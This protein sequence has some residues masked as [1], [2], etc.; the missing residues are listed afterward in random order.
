MSSSLEH[1][2]ACLPVTT[3]QLFD[4]GG[5]R[6]VLLGQGTF[7]RLVEENSGRVLAYLRVFKINHVHGYTVLQRDGGSTGHVQ[8]VAWGGQS[9]RLIELSYSISSCGEPVV[10]LVA[11]SAEY[12]A[13]DWVLAGCPSTDGSAAYLVTAHNAVLGMSVV[14][15]ANRRAIHLRQL[16][17]GVKSILY[18]A[19]I[20]PV[21]PT[22]LLVAAGTVFGE[23]IVWSCFLYDGNGSTANAISSIHHFFT[24]HEGSIFDVEISPKIANL[25]GD[26]SGR[27]LASCSDDRTVRIWDIS[28][29]E[30]ASPDQPSAYSTDGF[31]LRCTGFGQVKN[32]E[33]NAE[34][35][36]ASAFGHGARIW[37]IHFLA[38]Q[39]TKDKISLISRGEDAQCLVWDL[40]WGSS[41]ESKFK[42]TN[43]CSLHPHNGK[44]IWSLGMLTAGSKTTVYTG[45]NDGA[46]RTFNLVQEAGELVCP[47]R[48]T[49]IDDTPGS[50]NIKGGGMRAYEFVTPDHFLV[51][52]T[53]GEIQI[54]WAE[55]PNTADRRIACETLFV[56]ED[57]SSYSIISGLP[58][59]GVA[60]IG[61]KLGV[62]RL[63]DHET[64]S[65][66]TVTTAGQ[67]P[68]GLYLLDHHKCSDGSAN[69]KILATYT[70]LDTAEVFH[71]HLS[72]EEPHGFGISCASLIHNNEYL[73][74]GSRY[75]SFAVYKLQETGS[76]EPLLKVAR[77]HSKDGLT[78]IIPFTSLSPTDSTPSQYFLTSGRDAN[79][80]VNEL[81]VNGDA[82]SLRTVHSP[83][84]L[85]F[86]V[87]GAYIDNH[88]DLILYG[89]GG[90]GFVVWNESTQAEIAKIHCGGGHRRWAFHPSTR[91][92][93]SLLL[94]S[95]GG[96][97]ATHINAQAT[98]IK[99]LGT[100]QPVKG[101]PL[102]VTGSPNR[103]GPWGALETQR[104]LTA[105][106]SSPQHIACA[107]EDFFV[108]KIRT[109]PFFGLA[110]AIQGHCPKSHP[111]SEL[112]AEA[113]ANFLLCQTYS[114]STIKVFH[115]SCANE[116]GRFTLLASGTYTSNCLTQVRF[117]RTPS[118]LCLVTT[119]TDGHFT[120]WDI[121]AVLEQFY[122]LDRPLRLKQPLGSLSIAEETI[123]CEIR[124]QIHSNSIKTIDMV[125]LSDT[126]TLLLAGGDDNAITLTLLHTDTETGRPATITIPDAH[127]ASV[128][129][130]K[131]IEESIA[132]NSG[133]VQL[134]FASSGN[135]HRVKLW[136]VTID[137][138]DRPVLD[139][140]Q[141]DNVLDRYSPVADISSLDV[142][143][144][145]E[146]MKLLVC[147]VGMEW[148]TVEL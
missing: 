18:S 128:N 14:E 108:W 36:V 1:V 24:G 6:F 17:A 31:E 71:V 85:G 141:V 4:L 5:V 129:A 144:N 61:N 3:L 47:N 68:V 101:S 40:I 10:S 131:A 105:H 7:A 52:T 60:V 11:A 16:V 139:G 96:F 53:S 21:S 44:H 126:V 9:L 13:P 123:A 54:A 39:I 72:A 100:Y 30:I 88:N 57:L 49:R 15:E 134:S 38:E 99:A 74:L 109:I 20:V 75:G 12:L 41:S 35:C 146:G 33:L 25:R 62:V 43:T 65:L 135:D 27:L 115:L 73:G 2:D 112:R 92:G 50:E 42:L 63:Y 137:M 8:L 67:R 136:R 142:V 51:V 110:A 79:Y 89:F 29:C 119:S 37:G 78:R 90:M 26:L 94:W 98:Q 147:G 106:D 91:P 56:E 107:M 116:D 104:V 111:K 102:F 140:V 113:E 77:V 86:N 143:H 55:S 64:R 28:D 117:L 45:G 22:N 80:R 19:Q 103:S 118:S 58:Y 120:L 59:K 84:T 23:I 138:Q 95:Q 124:H 145:G 132:R 48:T 32:D 97:N 148:F 46:V 121:T 83:T 76:L 122:H 127:T 69:L 93:E 70:T 66:T 133:T 125:H 114:N 82:V 87:E 130:V 81:D 34:S